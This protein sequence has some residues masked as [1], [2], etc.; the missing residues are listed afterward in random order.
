MRIK[1]QWDSQRRQLRWAGKVVKE[2]GREA[3]GQ[4]AVLDRFQAAGWPPRIDVEDLVPAGASAKEWVR[5]TVTNLNRNLQG[6]RFHADGANHR[7]AWA[8]V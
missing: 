8:E 7:I 1:P 3:P 4:M 6:I 5:D 2:Y